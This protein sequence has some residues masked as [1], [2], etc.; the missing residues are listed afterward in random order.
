MLDVEDGTLHLPRVK[1]PFADFDVRT[2]CGLSL[3]Q[4]TCGPSWS[5]EPLAVRRCPDCFPEKSSGTI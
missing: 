4:A 1:D 2:A 5:V 3:M